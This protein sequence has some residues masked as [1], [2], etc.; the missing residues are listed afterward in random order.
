MKCLLNND[1]QK[2]FNVLTKASSVLLD[3]FSTQTEIEIPILTTSPKHTFDKFWQIQIHRQLVILHVTN[4]IR[5]KLF[6]S[7]EN[8]NS[9]TIRL[10]VPLVC[11]ALPISLLHRTY[12][13]VPQLK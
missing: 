4:E 9:A 8:L 13:D 11:R 2:T 1:I 7:D 12:I 10:P 6:P 3:I 5:K